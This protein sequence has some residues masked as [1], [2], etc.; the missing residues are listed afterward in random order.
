MELLSNEGKMSCLSQSAVRIGVGGHL[1]SC[2]ATKVVMD[3]QTP[4]LP[5]VPIVVQ[6]ASTA[7]ARTLYPPPPPSAILHLGMSLRVGLQQ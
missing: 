3:E 6:I 5:Q 1:G 4:K 2:F 7:G